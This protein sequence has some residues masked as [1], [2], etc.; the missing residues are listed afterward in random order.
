MKRP[1]SFGSK[2]VSK[3]YHRTAL[4]SVLMMREKPLSDAD[5]ISL[6]RS[7]GVSLEQIEGLIASYNAERTPPR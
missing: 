2:Q 7:H 1:R 3:A 5:K 6:S 4:R